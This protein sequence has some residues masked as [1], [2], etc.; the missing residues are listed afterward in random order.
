VSAVGDA[1]KVAVALCKRFEGFSPTPYA[2]PAGVATIGYG[3]T[4]YE[5]GTK[6]TL[7]DKLITQSEAELMLIRSLSTQYLPAVLKA[8]P[9]LIIYPE[10]LGAITDFCFNLGAARYRA[11]TLRKRIDAGDVER[12]REEILKWNKAGGRV[13]PGLV[14][15]RAAERALFLAGV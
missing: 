5:N 12:A 8:S 1:L 6:V 7:Q 4:F 3:N 9:G 11:S 13:L 15:R 10:R 14:K 2:C